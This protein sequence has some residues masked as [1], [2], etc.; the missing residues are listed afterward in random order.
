MT[1]TD[2][3]LVA[4][5]LRLEAAGSSQ[6]QIAAALGK[7]RHWVRFVALAKSGPAIG[8]APVG[9]TPVQPTEIDLQLCYP[10]PWAREIDIDAALRDVITGRK[11][12]IQYV[13][14]MFYIVENPLC[15]CENWE[16]VVLLPKSDGNL[17]SPNR[18]LRA[19][20][21]Y[22]EYALRCA[23]EGKMSGIRRITPRAASF[24]ADPFAVL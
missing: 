21:G 24:A 16:P 20:R 2:D 3:A 10:S 4:E 1:E 18:L 5:A 6:R 17:E 9:S 19:S 23:S 14:P 12:A 11:V 8:A 7:P 15:E 22:Q 13:I